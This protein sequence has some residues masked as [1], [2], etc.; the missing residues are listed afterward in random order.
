[1]TTQIKT[2]ISKTEG[3]WT[4]EEVATHSTDEPIVLISENGFRIE[5]RAIGDYGFQITRTDDPVRPSVTTPLDGGR[6]VLFT[7]ESHVDFALLD[8]ALRTGLPS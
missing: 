6:A 2:T 7:Q 4:Y 1:M 3:L 5:I 8:F